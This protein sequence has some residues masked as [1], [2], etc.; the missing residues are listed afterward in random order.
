M[1]GKGQMPLCPFFYDAAVIPILLPVSES[2]PV[3]NSIFTPI[4]PL[5]WD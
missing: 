4:E 1:G 2:P 3:I 5:S